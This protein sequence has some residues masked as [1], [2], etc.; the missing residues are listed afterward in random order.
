MIEQQNWIGIR[1]LAERGR[2]S[3]LLEA[4]TALARRSWAPPRAA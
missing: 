4:R 3:I 2:R 1:V